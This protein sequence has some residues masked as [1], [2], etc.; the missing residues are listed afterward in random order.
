MAGKYTVV[1][2]SAL[3]AILIHSGGVAVVLPLLR[4][5]RAREPSGAQIKQIEASEQL[6]AHELL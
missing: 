3:M 1:G 5:K 6:S 4:S 2:I